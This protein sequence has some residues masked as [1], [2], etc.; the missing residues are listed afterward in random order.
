MAKKPEKRGG[1]PALVI[2]REEIVEGG[3]H[4]GAWKVAYAD[5]VTA[6]MAFFL[7]MWL[8]N[9]TT[10]DQKRGLAD[11]F[12]TAGTLSR[13]QAGS[14]APFGGKTPFDNGALVSDRGAIT[15]I[16]GKLDPVSIPD[17][18]EDATAP[19]KSRRA[20]DDPDGKPVSAVQFE[21]A[22]PDDP[23]LP[24]AAA[25]PDHDP[26]GLSLGAPLSAAARLDRAREQQQDAQQQQ[27]QERER[28][29]DRDQARERDRQERRAF[30]QAAAQIRD[31]VSRDPALADLARQL[32]ID[33]TP[34]GLRIQ[35][36]DQDRTAMF[37]VGS[38]VPNDRARLM[39]GKIAPV[40]SRLTEHI[41]IA[42]HTDNAAYPAG[43][44]RS[45]WELSAD[46]ANATRRLLIEAGVQDARMDSV[47]G[48]AD[49]D[50]LLPSD[51]SAAVNRR[52]AIT[53][54]RAA[55]PASGTAPGVAP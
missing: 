8:L 40:L 42:G 48:A 12:A 3:H 6:M 47:M 9:A 36:M 13:S 25:A 34:E 50:P 26:Q 41:A 4:G 19:P 28:A 17:D 43:G 46:R 33:E 21:V 55:R 23:D 51:P 2:R 29:R 44:G 5:F 27:A 30:A 22:Q 10:E 15:V 53:V 18:P 45:N 32:A 11:Y 52:I 35:L 39:L 20:Q 16:P 7:L 24:R 38:A 31:A 54:L 1:K 14:G 49:R 37:A